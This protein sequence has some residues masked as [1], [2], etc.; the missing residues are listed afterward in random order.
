MYHT[1]TQLRAWTF[2]SQEELNEKRSASNQRYREEHQSKSQGK[3]PTTFF[4]SEGEERTLCE[5]Y[6]FLLRDFCKKFQPPVPPAVV[7]TSC[8]YFKR[9][10]IYNTAMDYHPKYIMLT[11][12]YLA[13]KVEEFNVSISQF[14]GNL[15]PEEQEKMAELILSHELLVMQQLNFQLTVH[16]P[17]R[18]MEGLFI[19]IKTRFP[20][21][22][23][24]ELLRKG[25][26]EFINRSLAT[27]ACLLCSPSQ[28]AL[29][30][31]V[32]SS[33]RQDTNIDKYVTDFLMSGRDDPKDLPDVVNTIKLIRQMVRKMPQLNPEV[34]KQL[35]RKLEKCRNE[36][37]NPESLIYKKRLQDQLNT[38]DEEIYIKHQQDA[39]ETRRKEK[40]LLMSV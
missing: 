10:Y 33:S 4:L 19:D 37:L 8:A 23:Q 9:F 31:L 5:S 16:N 25:A 30:A 15:R 11:C 14:C 20:S 22:K 29:A 26:E 36:E 7:G 3:D 39:E 21:L 34:A 18:P 38:E 2:S 32:S 12:V 1:S 27:D 6:E 28:I 13:C 35:E 40:E 17:Y 24:P